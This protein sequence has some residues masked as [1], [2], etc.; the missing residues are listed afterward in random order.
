ML[1]TVLEAVKKTAISGVLE[2]LP[3]IVKKEF[4]R[5][6]AASNRRVPVAR[7][8]GLGQCQFQSNLFRKTFLSGIATLPKWFVEVV[9]VAA[10]CRLPT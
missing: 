5:H 8:R 4:D 10:R 6:P 9:D 7:F 1:S 2:F 3:N